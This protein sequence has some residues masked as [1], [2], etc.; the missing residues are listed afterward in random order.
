M[1]LGIIDAAK[2][3]RSALQ[4]AA[5]IA[6][7]FLTTEA[8]IVDEPEKAAA[9]WAAATW[10]TDFRHHDASRRTGEASAVSLRRIASRVLPA[11]GV[12]VDASGWRGTDP[13]AAVDRQPGHG[14]QR[15]TAAVKRAPDELIVEEP[16]SIQL[17]GTLVADH[18]A[19]ARPRLR[20]GGRLLPHRGAARRRA[21]SRGVRYCATARAID[22]RVQ[23]RHRRDRRAGA[24]ADAPPR[25]RRRRAAG[26]CG[27][28]QLDDMCATP[29]AAGRRRPPMPLDLLAA[30]PDRGRRRAATC[31]RRPAPSTPRRCSTATAAS[32]ASARTS[33]AT[34]PSTR[35][36]ARCCSTGAA[37]APPGL[38]L[39]V[40]G[41][42]SVEMV[43]KAW[44]AG[45]GTLVAVSAPTSL[46]VDAARRGNLVAR[47][48]RPRRPVQRL[49]ARAARD[50]SAPGA[51]V[52]ACTACAWKP[53][54]ASSICSA[55]ASGAVD[56]EAVTAA[57]KAAEANECQVI[58]AAIARPQGRRGGD[59]AG[60]RLRALAQLQ[61]ALQARR[62]R[63]RRQL[64]VDHRGQRVRQGHA[65]GDAAARGCT[66]S[67][68]RRA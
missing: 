32:L 25:H 24:G 41:R 12:R 6:A 1:K 29:G 30:M 42:A 66:R 58:T 34:T 61:T 57:V 59:G 49:R 43:Q 9:P 31:S 51:P 52:V 7:L 21:R 48:L 4:N 11:F 35:W 37:P 17:D 56:R 40:S 3:T 65:G 63:R 15:R 5:S 13:I 55:S 19:H 27:S 45:F 26:W 62:P 16:M 44:A 47:R 14:R 33:A 53:A 18:D 20:A 38:G 8:V 22:D 2:V 50:L 39:F 23:R 60:A 64:R 46:A 54:S 67:C 68:R 36:S 28:D 10:I